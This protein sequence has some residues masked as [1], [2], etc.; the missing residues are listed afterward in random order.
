MEMRSKAFFFFLFFAVAVPGVHAQHQDL[1]AGSIKTTVSD[2]VVKT[3]L[4]TRTSGSLI[5]IG[6]CR[7]SPDGDIVETD[8]IGIGEPH[9][10]KSPDEALDSLAK[11]DHH[12]T[13]TRQTDGLVQVRDGRTSAAILSLTIRQI[14]LK[15][16]VDLGDAIRKLLSAP[17][18]KAFLDRNRIEM[19]VV[20]SSSYLSNEQLTRQRAKNPT[21]PKYSRTLTNV[22][23]E[24]A[25]NSIVSVFPGV[26]VYSECPGRITITADLTGSPRWERMQ[27]E[28]NK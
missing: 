16:V 8:Q 11:I 22:T 26:W 12:I 25:L 6:V 27:P 18:I 9:S 28:S 20:Y 7:S 21:A 14:E 5:L 4:Y 13:W 19:P 2:Y 17:E 10:S 1:S 3:F 24:Q 15:D 23:L